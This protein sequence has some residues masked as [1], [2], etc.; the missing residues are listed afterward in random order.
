MWRLVALTTAFLLV[1]STVSAQN[2]EGVKKLPSPDAGSTTEIGKSAGE[3]LTGLSYQ[4][5][6]RWLYN[7]SGYTWK[8][9]PPPNLQHDICGDEPNAC[10]AHPY[11]GTPIH[12]P[13]FSNKGRDLGNKATFRLQGFIADSNDVSKPKTIVFDQELEVTDESG[14]PHPCAKFTSHDPAGVSLNEPSQGDIVVCGSGSDKAETWNAKYTRQPCKFSVHEPTMTEI[15]N[16]KFTT[17]GMNMRICADRTKMDEVTYQKDH[18]KSHGGDCRI[19][20]DIH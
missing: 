20:C 16:E 10:L 15:S 6:R 14:G 13:S 11:M 8:I 12:Y 2:L 1:G 19:G 7:P 5:C 18:C 9:I 3:L 17:P 4:G